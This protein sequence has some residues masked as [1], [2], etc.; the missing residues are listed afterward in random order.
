MSEF[1]EFSKS[2]FDTESDTEFKELQELQ[3]RYEKEGIHFVYEENIIKS[4]PEINTN[5]IFNEHPEK[6]IYFSNF[7]YN[8]KEKN[9]CFDNENYKLCSDNE[10]DDEYF[11][12]AEKIYSDEKVIIVKGTVGYSYD[13][14][15][16]KLIYVLD[17]NKI[18]IGSHYRFLQSESDGK[19]FFDKYK[20]TNGLVVLN[21]TSSDGKTESIVQITNNECELLQSSSDSIPYFRFPRSKDGVSVPR[22]IYNIFKVFQD[23][24]RTHPEIIIPSEFYVYSNEKFTKISE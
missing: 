6:L 19:L 12:I 20:M 2:S 22:A 21:K 11:F 15:D 10:C 8:Y 16:I 9:F 23:P 14:K 1:G 17:E 13:P 3:E 7:E 18:Y 5:I 4:H 24:N